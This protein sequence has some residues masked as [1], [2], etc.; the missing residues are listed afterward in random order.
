MT[1]RKRPPPIV[2]SDLEPR[3]FYEKLKK[4]DNTIIN[5]KE[6]EKRV[7]NT[8]LKLR[9]MNIKDIEEIFSKVNDKLSLEFEKIPDADREVIRI[10]K[11]EEKKGQLFYKSTGTSRGDKGIAGVWFPFVSKDKRFVKLEDKYISSYNNF[12]GGVRFEE[13]SEED[14]SAMLDLVRNLELFKYGRFIDYTN[15]SISARLYQEKL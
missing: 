14:K 5:F 7:E 2:V 9:F 10:L 13:L 3:F 15:A 4:L 1:T 8:V 12:E 6:T 11:P